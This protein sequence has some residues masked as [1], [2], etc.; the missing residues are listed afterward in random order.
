MNMRAI[1]ARLTRAIGLD[2]ASL[3]DAVLRRAIERR[4]GATGSLSKYAA[5]LDQSEDE[6]EA[7]IEAVVVGESWFLRHPPAFAA[8]SQFA[9]TVYA[10]RRSGPF[11][12]ASVPC[13]NGEEP[14]SIALTL[15]ELGA[16]PARIAIDAADIS[17]NAIERARRGVYGE[18]ALRAISSAQRS[19]F[20]RSTSAGFEGSDELKSCVTFHHL[21][22]LE[23]PVGSLPGPYDAFFCRNLLIYLTPAARMQALNGI[24][25]RLAPG[26]LLFLGHAERLEG[27]ADRFRPVDRR[28]AFAFE[29]TAQIRAPEPLKPATPLP[30]KT[31]ALRRE[32]AARTTSGNATRAQ[33]GSGTGARTKSGGQ[34]AEPPADLLEQAK[35]LANQRR[36]AEAIEACALHIKRHGPSAQVYQFLGTIHQAEGRLDEARKAFERAIYLDPQSEESLLAMALVARQQGDRAGYDRFERRARRASERREHK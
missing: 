7:L 20:F 28:G 22:L 15:L 3:G 19:R 27:F 31:A 6:M 34:A 21:N 10:T 9:S 35:S 5:L 18:R 4:A 1:E 2:P 33:S 17:T 8:L 13:A 26:G 12:V 23:P 36:Y 29:F 30:S 32:S 16:S 25:E 11:R 24:I 14:Y